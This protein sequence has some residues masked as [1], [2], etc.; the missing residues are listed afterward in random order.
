MTNL[1][2]GRNRKP[3]LSGFASLVVLV[4]LL[5]CSGPPKHPAWSNATGGEQNERLMWQAVH[6]K[7]WKN[8]ERRLASSFVGVDASGK[9]YDRAGWVERWK[10]AGLLNYS[11]GEATVQPEGADM[12]VTYVLDLPLAGTANAAPGEHARV[13]SVWQQVKSGWIQTACSMT[14]IKSE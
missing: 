7:D 1:R 8:F 5:G 4:L 13:I 12:V 3:A 9:E 14:P 2:P 6:N 11:L 10:N